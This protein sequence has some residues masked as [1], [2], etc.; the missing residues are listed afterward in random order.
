MNL[1]VILPLNTSKVRDFDDFFTKA[2]SSISI[3]KIKPSELVIVHTNEDSLINYL[4]SF[5]F[6]DLKGYPL[7]VEMES[8]QNG[9]E[10]KILIIATEIN[11]KPIDDS[12]FQINTDGFSMMSY[13]EYME[14]LKSMQGGR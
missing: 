3:Q 7:K 6:G 14:K 12:V 1:S 8:N 13:S 4:E 11:T 9:M 10:I 2:I 5:D